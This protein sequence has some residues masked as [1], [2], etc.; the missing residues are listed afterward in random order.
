MP[1]ARGRPDSSPLR[2]LEC[3]ART[4]S[5]DR[6]STAAAAAAATSA[7]ATAVLEQEVLFETSQKVLQQ[8]D[9]PRQQQQEEGRACGVG[10]LPFL[11]GKHVLI[12]GATGFIGKGAASGGHG[13]VTGFIGVLARVL[14]EKILREQPR[15]G[16]LYLLIQPTARATAAH[17]LTQQVVPSPVFSLLRE[18]HGEGYGAFMAGKLTA[19]QGNVGEDGLGLPAH[20]AAALHDSVDLIFNFAATVDFEAEYDVALNINTMGPRRVLAFAKKCRRLQLLVH[21]STAYVNGQREGRCMERPF[22]PGDSIAAEMLACSP[23]PSATTAVAAAAAAVAAAVAATSPAAAAAASSA[24]AADF[25]AA[26]AAAAAA[27]AATTAAAAAA[28]SPAATSQVPVLDLDEEVALA[29]RERAAV[30]AGAKARGASAEEVAA[31]VEAHMSALGADRARTFGWQDA[32]ALCKAMGEMALVE[33][34]EGAEGEGEV[35]GKAG[36]E[37]RVPVVVV[38]PSIVESALH[39]P[40]P[41][42]IE[43]FRV[44]DPVLMAFAKGEIPGFHAPPH[45]ICDIIPV[46]LLANAILAIAASNAK[47][48]RNAIRPTSKHHLP[49]VYHVT[50]SVANPLC[51]NELFAATTK[52][53]AANPMKRKDGTAISVSHMIAFPWPVLFMAAIWFQ[54]ELPRLLVTLDPRNGPAQKQR[55]AAKL[56][57]RHNQY[58]RLA[59]LYMPYCFGKALFDSSNMEHLFSAMSPEEQHKFNFNVRNINWNHYL[60]HVHFPGLRKFVLKEKALK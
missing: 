46:D 31:A 3:R 1:V 38:R 39:E 21:V 24:A 2:G 54:Y 29:V 32:Y 59:K 44:A 37:A 25:A 41:G 30:E 11:E 20:A 8:Q 57:K 7:G 15:V 51:F 49:R 14:V 16:Q 13:V 36:G 17:R 12:T 60:C 55:Q 9:V 22:S 26:A 18:R 42:W 5:F 33:Q 52:H 53:F 35:G 48:P 19:V 34:Q 4:K 6:D 45:G 58:R 47:P 23:T 40:M 50:S 56:T 27:T 10:I 28:T 43:G